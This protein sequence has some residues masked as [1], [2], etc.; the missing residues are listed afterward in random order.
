MSIGRALD[1]G[2]GRGGRQTWARGSTRR[3][4]GGGG[5]VGGAGH[6]EEKLS[7]LTSQCFLGTRWAVPKEQRCL[8]SLMAQAHPSCSFQ[9]SHFPPALLGQEP[10]DQRQLFYFF[11]R[12][13]KARHA[14]NFD[15][16]GVIKALLEAYLG[17]KSEIM[18]SLFA[19]SPHPPSTISP[20]LP[21][22][23]PPL[24]NLEGSSQRCFNY[25]LTKIH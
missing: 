24:K 4:R 18:R 23:P 9:D 10:G 21:Y 1:L 6:E 2:L 14:P 7:R 13:T 11:I 20:G 17:Q 8:F 16:T 15:N 12:W 19:P 22:S 25:S 3:R 5:A